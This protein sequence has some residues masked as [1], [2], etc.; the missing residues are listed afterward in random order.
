MGFF[1][2]ESEEEDA[3][4]FHNRADAHGDDMNGHGLGI[5]EG[6]RVVEAGLSGNGFDSGA[7][8]KG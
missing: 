1:R 7:G 8:G 6:E 2:A 4:G 3:L 5:F